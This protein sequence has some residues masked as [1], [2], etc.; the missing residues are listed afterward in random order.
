MGYTDGFVVKFQ[1]EGCNSAPAGQ[2]QRERLSF[3]IVSEA[4][5]FSEGSEQGE[6]DIQHDRL[7]HKH[8]HICEGILRI[9]EGRHAATQVVL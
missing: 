2:F 5:V 8:L 1:A 4:I 6:L 9:F 3:F 7:S